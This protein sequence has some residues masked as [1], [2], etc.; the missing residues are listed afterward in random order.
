M[1]TPFII[2]VAGG[3]GSGK[4]TVVQKLLESLG[5]EK[6]VAIAH[7]NYYRDQSEKPTR[8]RIKTNYDHPDSLENELLVQH[9]QELQAGRSIEQPTY[10]FAQH[11]RSTKIISTLPKKVIIVEGILIFSVPELRAL[12]DLKVFVDTDADIRFVRRL[13]RDTAERGR[14]VES[15]ITQ[16]LATV[17]PMYDQFV[18]PSKRYADL[19]IPEGGYNTAAL[20]VLLARVREIE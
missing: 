18:E 13:Q 3:S 15:V 14:S 8:E 4:T 9:L 12:F 7:D 5:T 20:E 1:H 17:K 19:I 16:Y 6:A 11:T 2:G 10:D